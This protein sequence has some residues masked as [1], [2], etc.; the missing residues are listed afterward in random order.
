MA[1]LWCLR[2]QRSVHTIHP[3]DVVRRRRSCVDVA[4]TDVSVAV[5]CRSCSYYYHSCRVAVVTTVVV[6][7]VIVV[8]ALIVVVVDVI[9]RRC[10]YCC[11]C[12]GHHNVVV[13]F[14]IVVV[15]VICHCSHCHSC[16]ICRRCRRS[17]A[18]ASV[19][20]HRPSIKQT[21]RH[22]TITTS[23]SVSAEP[24]LRRQQGSGLKHCASINFVT[25]D[26]RRVQSTASRTGPGRSD[27][28]QIRRDP[29]TIPAVER[30]GETVR[31]AIAAWMRLRRTDD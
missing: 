24:V 18:S 30:E 13:V 15:T 9:C 6:F 4:L 14:W 29:S 5:M 19:R 21:W 26:P 16:R 11:S 17:C 20:Q 27:Q 31:R 22:T 23:A 1:A 10:S 7:V 2:P 12:S 25:G 28:W 8:F 3:L